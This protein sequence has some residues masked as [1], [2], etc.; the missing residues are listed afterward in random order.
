MRG[1][2]A[3][4]VIFVPKDAHDRRVPSNLVY[5]YVFSDLTRSRTLED[6]ED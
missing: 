2:A 3:T 1:L 4:E 5:K 6:S